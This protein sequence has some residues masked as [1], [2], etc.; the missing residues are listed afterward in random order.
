MRLEEMSFVIES[1]FHGIMGGVDYLLSASVDTAT[2]ESND[3]AEIILWNL[4]I[5]R[6]TLEDMQDF[7][8]AVQDQYYAQKDAMYDHSKELERRQKIVDSYLV[9]YE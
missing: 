6:P 8:I 1:M 3:D 9:K 5:E 7:F 4:P 2:G